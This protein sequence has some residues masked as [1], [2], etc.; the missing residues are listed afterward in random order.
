MI[1]IGPRYI[2]LRNA[3]RNAG[4]Q[5]RDIAVQIGL[6]ETSMCHRMQGKYPFTISEAYEI[7]DILH[8]PY[9]D[10]PILFPKDGA[11]GNAPVPASDNAINWLETFSDDIKRTV[12]ARLAMAIA[13]ITAPPHQPIPLRR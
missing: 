4:I 9:S 5:Q 12:D 8:R 13:A 11:S 3:L 7:L 10:L 1:P 2:E 6:S